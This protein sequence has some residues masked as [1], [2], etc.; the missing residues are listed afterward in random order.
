MRTTN[1]DDSP[2]GVSGG[3]DSDR[4]EQSEARTETNEARRNEH[5]RF[6]L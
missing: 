1:C 2:S 3:S 4:N 6:P 5:K